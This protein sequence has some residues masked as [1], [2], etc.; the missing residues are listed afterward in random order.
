MKDD[1]TSHGD[2]PQRQPDAGTE[3]TDDFA[4]EE[5]TPRSN[6]RYDQMFPVLTESEI[7]R[8]I[9]FGASCRY[10]AG[11]MLYRAGGASPGMF[12]LL[13]GM[14]R[15]VRRDGLGHRGLL[16]ARV[17]RGEFTSD[18]GMLSGKPGLVDAEVTEHVE[19]VVIPPDRLRALMIA[20]AE[21]GERIMRALILRRVAAIERGQG[22]VLVGAPDDA[23][24]LALQNFLR[25]NGQPHMT[26][27]VQ[28]SEAIALLERLTPV[29]SDMPLVLC[30]NGT[31]LRNPD[32]AQLA[33][34]LGLVPEFDP[35]HIYD[36]AVVGAGPA[37]LAAAVYAASE[38]LSVAAFDCRAPGGQAGASSRIENYLGF[39]TGISGQA[40]AGRAF[41]QAQKFGA[42]IGI[43]IEVTALH[44]DRYP[45]EIELANAQRIAA[46]TV[47][48]A[49]GAE[50]RRP[51][52]QGLA[53]FEGRG[54][55]YWA[56]PIEA[57]LCRNEPVLLVGGGNSAGQAIAFLAPQVAHVQVLVRG[58]DL[59][60]SMSR[61]LIERITSLPNVTIDTGAAMTS[62]EGDERLERVHYRRSDGLDAHLATHHLFLFIGA[63]PNTGWLRTCGVSLDSKGFVLTGTDVGAVAATRTLPLETSVDGVFAIGDVRS[64]STKRVAAAVGEGAAV[65][66]QIHTFLAARAGSAAIR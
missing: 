54:V 17:S 63:D 61:Y 36:V 41:N 22:A 58:P 23:Q 59:E 57:R 48:I 46:R 27:D 64:G 30:P 62:L 4:F 15:Y 44:C 7:E 43:P 2:V 66:A 65:I 33:S 34:C 8:V 20:E 9:R 16:R 18:I 5:Q 52:V 60:R 40:L 6:P 24:L 19:A 45:L 1:A 56:T 39:P 55:Y 47:V 42:H 38:G 28:D 49:S 51:A 32:E 50:Y 37:G 25:R 35:A 11:E 13:S 31:V 21:L 29:R 10:A 53:R 14:I 3:G 12:V 26:L